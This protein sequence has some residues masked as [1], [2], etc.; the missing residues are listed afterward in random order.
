[1]SETR[2]DIK[3]QISSLDSAFR[4]T[5][6]EHRYVTPV[7]LA[8]LK[9]PVADNLGNDMPH[10]AFK[11]YLTAEAPA[12]LVKDHQDDLQYIIIL[13]EAEYKQL[14]DILSLMIGENLQRD[15]SNYRHKLFKNYVLIA[16]NNLQLKLS[17]G[18]IKQ[19]TLAQYMQR[20]A[21]LP[22]YSNP[23]LD[24]YKV[25]DLKS[26][27]RMPQPAFES[28]ISFLIRGDNKMKQSGLLLQ[29]FTSNGKNYYYITQANWLN[30]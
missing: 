30:K 14:A 28:Y 16:K 11:Y 22:L 20:V 18:E 5:G 12:T 23:D 29:H 27:S 26:D 17:K 2:S 8:Q 3:T 24:K 10:N 6:R 15:A 4:L 19:L 13:N 21:G 25:I 7:V 1:M 9:A